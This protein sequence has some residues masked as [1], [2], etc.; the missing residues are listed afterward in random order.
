MAAAASSIIPAGALTWIRPADE[1]SV[2]PNN[3]DLGERI[4]A[5]ARAGDY[6]SAAILARRVLCIEA[7][8]HG[9]RH[10][11]TKATMRQLARFLSHY[12]KFKEEEEALIALVQRQ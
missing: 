5:H 11:E 4:D 7:A 10:E 3:D 9:M 2:V 8:T 12:P 6:M 1:T